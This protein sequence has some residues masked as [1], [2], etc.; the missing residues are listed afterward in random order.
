MKRLLAVGCLLL[1]IGYWS[2][3]NAQDT[4]AASTNPAAQEE[5]KGYETYNYTSAIDGDLQNYK[6][7]LE[8]RI[9]EIKYVLGLVGITSESTLQ[10]AASKDATCLRLDTAIKLLAEQK[11]NLTDVKMYKKSEAKEAKK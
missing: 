8:Q 11:K 7:S 1:V 4:S 10:E 5:L 9:G 2:F 3:V 6:K